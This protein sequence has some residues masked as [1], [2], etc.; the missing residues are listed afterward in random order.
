M[1]FPNRKYICITNRQVT[2]FCC[3]FKETRANN[4]WV[5]ENSISSRVSSKTIIYKVYHYLSVPYIA[6]EGRVFPGYNDPHR[7][8]YGILGSMT[9]HLVLNVCYEKF[10]AN[11]CGQKIIKI[12]I[13]IGPSQSFPYGVKIDFIF[14]KYRKPK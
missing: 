7:K 10:V 2:I 6:N 8:H 14:H 9:F 11:F 1:K 5:I 12:F 13:K 3:W 4:L